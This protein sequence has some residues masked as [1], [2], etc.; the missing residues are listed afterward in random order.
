MAVDA[1]DQAFGRPEENAKSVLYRLCGRMSLASDQ[2][3]ELRRQNG[4]K[5][6]TICRCQ[7]FVDDQ[8]Y[9]PD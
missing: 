6:C 3:L 7:P 9:L 4:V 8:T 1:E 2:M 5:Y